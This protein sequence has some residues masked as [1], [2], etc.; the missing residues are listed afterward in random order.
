MVEQIMEWLADIKE[1]GGRIRIEEGVDAAPI[2]D[3]IIF[4]HPMNAGDWKKEKSRNRSLWDGRAPYILWDYGC[5]F[6]VRSKDQ[7]T[8]LYSYPSDCKMVKIEQP[9]EEEFEKMLL[10]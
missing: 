6:K 3:A 5:I 1:N 8:V 9:T 4:S 7:E 2:Y 10:G